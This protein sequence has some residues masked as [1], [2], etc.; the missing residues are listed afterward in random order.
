MATTAGC[1]W[2]GV[3]KSRT[4][5]TPAP[6]STPAASRASARREVLN[7]RSS[8]SVLSSHVPDRDDGGT[9]SRES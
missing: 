6:P 4:A 5:V 1:A 7:F 2:A 9:V 3:E 8:W